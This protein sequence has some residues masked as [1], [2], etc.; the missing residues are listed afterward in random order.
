MG[1]LGQAFLPVA[2]RSPF[3]I[4]LVWSKGKSR[5]PPLTTHQG[6]GYAQI[7][8]RCPL[9]KQSRSPTHRG[10][11]WHASMY[12]RCIRK[13]QAGDSYVLEPTVPAPVPRLA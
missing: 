5:L 7:S 2:V 13:G 8:F 3:T 4:Q 1:H 11:P 12:L 9:T 6:G 10:W